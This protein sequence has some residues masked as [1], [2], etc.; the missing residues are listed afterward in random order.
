[1]KPQQ[2]DR[3]GGKLGEELVEQ[4]LRPAELPKE[5]VVAAEPLDVRLERDG[6]ACESVE[7]VEDQAPTAFLHH[8]GDPEIPHRPQD[9]CGGLSSESQASL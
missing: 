8:V 9:G 1:M 6:L 4:T 5:L 2:R 3:L 7:S